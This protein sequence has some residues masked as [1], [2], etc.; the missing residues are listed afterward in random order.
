MNYRQCLTVL[1]AAIL[2]AR[3]AQ[4]AGQEAKERSARTAC[5]SGDYTKG[6]AL[7]SELFV[8]TRNPTYIYNQGRCFEQNLRYQDAIGR[9]QEYLRVN[10]KLSKEEKD[11]A[12]KH[13]ADC[14]TLLAKQKS[15]EVAIPPAQVPRP[16]ATPAASGPDAPAT[17]PAVRQ[18]NPQPANEPGSGLRVAGI[19]TAGVGVAALAGGILF[20]VK[21]NNLASDIQKVDGYTP[22]KKSDQS[23]YQT[24]GWVGYGVGAACIAAGAVL[25]VLGL[26]SDAPATSTVGFLPA[27]GPG[28]AGVVLKGSF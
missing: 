22:S 19:V 6:V 13:I 16:A 14:E 18:A 4:G 11:D 24:L 10:K 28:Q 17:V 2:G 21:A 5:L 1:L 26:R 23:T 25:Y 12:E 7:L 20:N 27:V 8:D 3:S 9:F 15:Q